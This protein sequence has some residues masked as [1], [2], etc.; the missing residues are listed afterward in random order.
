VPA[1]DVEDH[2]LAGTGKKRIAGARRILCGRIGRWLETSGF[3][4]HVGGAGDRG[5]RN[6]MGRVYCTCCRRAFV[7]VFTS[8]IRS[9]GQRK[10]IRQKF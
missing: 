3:A 1:D 10:L 6:G 4:G 9:A 5:Y 8:R 2:A 7:A